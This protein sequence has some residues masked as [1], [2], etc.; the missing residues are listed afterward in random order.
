MAKTSFPQIGEKYTFKP[1]FTAQHTMKDGP[2]IPK[3]VVFIYS[4]SFE[5]RLK[6]V[7][8]LSRS[9]YR[10][11]EGGAWKAYNLITSDKNLIVIKLPSGASFTAAAMEEAIFLG[12]KEFLIAGAAGGIKENISISDIVLCTKAIRDEGA[13]HHYIKA[14][15]YAF[16]DE[17]LNKKLETSLIKKNI[18]FYKGISW[19]TDA[20][21]VETIEEVK[22]YRKENVITV[23]MEASAFFAVAERRKVKTAAVFTISDVLGKKWTGFVDR[24]YKNNGYRKLA[25]IVKLFKELK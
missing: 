1:L 15:K 22:H 13:S 14:S 6:K 16:P 18:K 12:G 21:Y 7:L 10:L 4:N 9:K 24:D 23:E 20:P 2:K 8:D 3:R 5:N 11:G 25:N 17:L 19:T